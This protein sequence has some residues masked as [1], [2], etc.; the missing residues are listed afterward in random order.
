MTFDNVQFFNWDDDKEIINE[1]KHGVTFKEAA[2]VFKDI[3]ALVKRDEDHSNDEERFI[4]VGISEKPR[5]LIVCH[6]Y[7]ESDTI[8]RIISA[9]KATKNESA[10]YKGEL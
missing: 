10:D 6:C 1:K 9:R 3:H 7:R 8:I 5:L 4:I 2:S